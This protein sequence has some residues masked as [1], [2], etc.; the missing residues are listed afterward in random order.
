MYGVVFFF[1]KQKTAYEMLSGD[2]SSDVCSSDLGALGEFRKA[3]EID[4]KDPT[5]Q[6]NLGKELKAGGDTADAI[7]AFQRAIELKPDFEEAHYSLGIALR[8]Q[9]QTQAGQKE[10][11]ELKGLREFR[12]RL[13]QSK[14]LILQG[15]DALN[16][17]KLDDALAL[18]QKSID[19]S[20]ELPTGYYYLGVTWDRKAEPTRAIADYQKALELKPDYAQ[21]HSSLG[22]LLWRQGDRNRALQEFQQAVM[23]DPDLAEGHYNLGLALA[24]M[25]RLEESIS[26][27][28]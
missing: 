28:S 25:G 22:L 4:P 21:V 10:L 8:E 15:V 7:A 2:W 17:Q 18:F 11:E 24:R 19:Q 20:P 27:F 26:E 9:G 1:F 16:Q 23:N 14:Y 13:A 6:Y 12:A 5:A 3:V